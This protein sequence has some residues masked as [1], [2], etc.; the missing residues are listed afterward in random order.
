VV[1]QAAEVQAALQAMVDRAEVAETD[2]PQDQLPNQANQ[3]L[4]QVLTQDLLAKQ[5]PVVEV[6]VVVEPEKQEAP[7][8]HQLAEMV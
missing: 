1:A 6:Q 7:E 2:N 5:Q 3:I 8:D 4:E